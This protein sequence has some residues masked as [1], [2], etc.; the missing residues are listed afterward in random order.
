MFEDL[1]DEE[2]IDLGQEDE[3]LDEIAEEFYDDPDLAMERLE[4]I[5]Y[6]V[7]DLPL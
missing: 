2:R 1:T 7:D 5:G 4:E 3:V 6:D